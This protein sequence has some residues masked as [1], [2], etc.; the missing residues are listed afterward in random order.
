MLGPGFL[1]GNI[2]FWTDSHRKEQ[3]GAI[4]ANITAGKYN[5]ETGRWQFMSQETKDKLYSSLFLTGKPV[6]DD[7]E[8]PVKF[9][10]MMN[11]KTVENITEWMFE[12]NCELN[13]PD[14]YYSLWASD[15]GSNTIG[16]IEEFVDKL[17]EDLGLLLKNNHA[18][19]QQVNRNAGWM[20]VFH[21]VQ[22]RKG[23]IPPIS[24]D[25]SNEV[26]WQGEN[27]FCNCSLSTDY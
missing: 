14:E 1:G 4:V 22:K 5:M 6:L 18:I 27:W 12:S 21:G 19:Q 13:I 25:P 2:D 9:E 24:P 10:K 3:Y 17:N 16:S 23:R 7:L 26:R 8:Y 11:P 20:E 15:G